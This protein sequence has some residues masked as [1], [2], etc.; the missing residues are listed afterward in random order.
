[1]RASEGFC[2]PETRLLIPDKNGDPNHSWGRRNFNSSVN[3]LNTQHVPAS[4]LARAIGPKPCYI[5]TASCKERYNFFSFIV[6]GKIQKWFFLW[7]RGEATAVKKD[8]RM[9]DMNVEEHYSMLLGLTSSW[10]VVLVDMNMKHLRIDV[11]VEWR[12]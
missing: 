2:L 5:R 7:V 6:N 1:M 12:G 4:S 3:V 8:G 11:Y 10:T 9:S